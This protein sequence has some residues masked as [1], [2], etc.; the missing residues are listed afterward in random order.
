MSIIESLRDFIITC[1]H[2]GA[3]QPVL[4]DYLGTEVTGTTLEPLPCDP[5]FRQYVSQHFDLNHNGWLKPNEIEAA[6]AVELEDYE[7]L[8][9]VQGIGFLTETTYILIDNAPNLTGGALEKLALEEHA[10]GIR[11]ERRAGSEL[12]L[13]P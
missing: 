3:D 1:P 5:V 11:S 9:S 8:E 2:I 4:I 13:P 6:T 12:G 7:G 10:A